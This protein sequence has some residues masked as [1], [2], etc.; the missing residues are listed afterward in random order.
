MSK[1]TKKFRFNPRKNIYADG[2]SGG[3]F[4][5]GERAEH[6]EEI[7]K[8][9]LAEIL[10]A[11]EGDEIGTSEM[12]DIIGDMGHYC[13]KHKLDF[14]AVLRLALMNWEEER[15]AD[16]DIL[17]DDVPPTPETII[18]CVE[19]GLVQDVVAKRPLSFIV[20]DQDTEGCLEDDMIQIPGALAEAI[21]E[22]GGETIWKPRHIN[23]A[24]ISEAAV[25]EVL[26][27]HKKVA[28]E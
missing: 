17:I 2:E 6:A 22:E 23:D 14:K 4:N 25:S 9:H 26:D 13:D 19:S 24:T 20:V 10:H 7:L 27:L 16:S 18:V 28:N 8:H 21:R 15:G 12:S 5:N 3:S 11:P 1:A